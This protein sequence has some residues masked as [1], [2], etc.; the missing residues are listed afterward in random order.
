MYNQL[1]SEQRYTI[2]ILYQKEKTISF[3]AVTIGVSISTVSRE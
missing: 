3:I 2:S 1:I